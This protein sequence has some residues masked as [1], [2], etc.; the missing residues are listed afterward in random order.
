VSPSRPGPVPVPETAR[1]SGGDTEPRLLEGGRDGAGLKIGIVVSRF[2]HPIGQ[3]LL[4][5]ALTALTGHGVAAADITVARV[6]GA[7]ELPFLARRLADRHDAVICLGAVIRGE[8][9]HFE[10]VAREAARGIARLASERG[11]PVLFGVL[12]VETTEQARD[13]SGGRLGN[14]G[15]DAA[16]AAIEMA[17]LLRLL[18]VR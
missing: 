14:R 13:R 4:D 3:R 17:S 11:I 12:T 5:G 15:A 6:P 18:G 16:L 7:F 2:N 1:A 10:F 9:P 8:T